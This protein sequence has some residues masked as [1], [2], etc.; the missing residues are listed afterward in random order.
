MSDPS[1]T[2]SDSD[3]EKAPPQA[4][5]AERAPRFEDLLARTEKLVQR[6]EHGGLPLEESIKGYEEGILLIRSAQKLLDEAER[7]IDLLRKREDETPER[8]PF[9]AP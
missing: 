6:L 2:P 1:H 7:R 8:T 4:P 9:P 5:N 3:A